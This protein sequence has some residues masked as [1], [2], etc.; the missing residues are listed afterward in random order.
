ML[1]VTPLNALYIDCTE[2]SQVLNE[3]GVDGMLVC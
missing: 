1:L 2:V 3:E